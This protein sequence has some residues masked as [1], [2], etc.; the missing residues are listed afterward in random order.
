MRS[1][2]AAVVVVLALVIARPA[3]AALM[4]SYD[5]ASL[6]FEAE[7]VV[8]V[9]VIDLPRI[10]SEHRDFAQVR[11]Q[12]S[13]AG[14]ALHPGDELTIETT[15][16]DAEPI[17]GRGEGKPRPAVSKER[18]LFLR[19][20]RGPNGNAATTAWGLEPSGMRIFVD[21]RVHGF[22]QEMNPGCYSPVPGEGPREAPYTR[23]EF[24]RS[25]E[26]ALATARSAHALLD[27]L[28]S[29][30]RTAKLLAIVGPEPDAPPDAAWDDRDVGSD[31]LG[32]S[33]LEAFAR[34]GNVPALL[35]GIARATRVDLFMSRLHV[36]VHQLVA[37]AKGPAPVRQRVAAMHLLTEGTDVWSSDDASYRLALPSLLSDPAPEVR[38]AAVDA[39]YAADGVPRAFLDALVA[40]F[41]VER[42]PR[43]RYALFVRA[44]REAITARLALAPGELPIA[45]GLVIHGRA[46]LSWAVLDGSAGFP[47]KITIV[48]RK[49][50]AIIARLPGPED[51]S[52]AGSSEV[53]VVLRPLAVPPGI[54]PGV[55]DVQADLVIGDGD[56]RAGR[57][58][59]KRTLALGAMNLGPPRPASVVAPPVAPVADAVPL[60]A[61]P[62]SSRWRMLVLRP[63]P[64]IVAGALLGLALGLLVVQRRRRRVA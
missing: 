57:P 16:Y 38:L 37:I 5:I 43:V 35:E 4:Q 34:D 10:A 33:I 31:R 19:R 17:H 39:R 1:L 18:V 25:L 8:L 40:R 3:S 62:P 58:S 12:R 6:A 11:V 13:F 7:E 32:A 50:G 21:G 48:L 15:C 45:R 60:E 41:R 23:E 36:P 61:E 26:R 51:L 14:S 52:Y 49:D 2:L 46:S 44:K 30:E 42:D 9:D 56:V 22:A 54:A 27:E 29:P 28:A 63:G 55:Y 47:E 64:R 24:E 20:V 53:T 59:V